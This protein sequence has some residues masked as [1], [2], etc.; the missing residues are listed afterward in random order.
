VSTHRFG[1][2]W[3][4]SILLVKCKETLNVGKKGWTDFGWKLNKADVTTAFPEAS[5]VL[6][7][8]S[9]KMRVEK[10]A[11]F[12]TNH[13]QRLYVVPS[14]WR[15]DLFSLKVGPWLI[16]GL[17]LFSLKDY[18][19]NH[20]STQFLSPL[21]NYGWYNRCFHVALPVTT[22]PSP[23][24]S[25]R[26]PKNRRRGQKPEGGHTFKLLYWMYA[27]TRGSNVKW[28]ALISNGGGGHHWPPA[29]NDP[30]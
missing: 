27:A 20:G 4:R 12:D 19:G 14:T 11:V 5:W 7:L 26:G 29:G 13:L 8:N 1:R 30:V 2:K 3:A 22:S 6:K 10:T 23:G 21:F 16:F 17:D 24:F 15:L 9:A 25:S 18:L 28:G